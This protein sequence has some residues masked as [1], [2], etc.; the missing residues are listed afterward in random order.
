MTNETE[1]LSCFPEH[2]YC[3]LYR[4]SRVLLA[5]LSCSFA[6][7]SGVELSACWFMNTLDVKLM[8][9]HCTL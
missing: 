7:D 8:G 6:Q 1:S 5:I 9:L 3:F 2:C 4:L